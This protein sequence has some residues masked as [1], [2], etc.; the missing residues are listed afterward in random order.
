M[1]W[2]NKYQ[3]GGTIKPYDNSFKANVGRLKGKF[4]QNVPAS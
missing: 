2:I 1:D 3:Q 4:R